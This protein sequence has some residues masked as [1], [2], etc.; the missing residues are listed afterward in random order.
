MRI[1]I[2]LF[3]LFSTSLF[4]EE[5]DNTSK[6][7]GL[8]LKK[9]VVDRIIYADDN[10]K[11]D[12]N[13]WR[14][15]NNRVYFKI[16]DNRVYKIGDKEYILISIPGEFK[17]LNQTLTLE[18]DGNGVVT[19]YLKQGTSITYEDYDM[20][21][22]M[23]KSLLEN[24][25]IKEYYKYSNSIATGLLT[26]P[27]KYRLGLGKTTSSIIDGGINI[28][29]FIGWKFRL[30]SIEPN[31]FTTFIFGSLTSISYTSS[32]NKMITGDEIEV[33]AG[34]SYGGGFTFSIGDVTPGII[35][36]YDIGLGDLGEHYTYH[37]KLWISFSVNYDF[38]SPKKNSMDQN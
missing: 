35:F 36:G 38:I 29:P 16:V 13:N 34:I 9:G 30:S 3:L 37:N 1:A 23:E 6:E 18:K 27:F 25:V 21:F 14:K 12:V 31:Y 4:S 11:P 32:T 24:D 10:K 26:A 2:L 15:L 5:N 7:L 33:G 19:N 17:N 28:G 8:R 22:W 20:N